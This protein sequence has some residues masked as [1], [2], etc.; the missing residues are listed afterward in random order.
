MGAPKSWRAIQFRI[1]APKSRPVI[2]F[3]MRALTGRRVIQFGMRALTGQ[4]VIEAVKAPAK[5][6]N[7]SQV[8]LSGILMG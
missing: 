3:G 8:R 4:P 7:G 1:R 6:T 2:Q 5:P